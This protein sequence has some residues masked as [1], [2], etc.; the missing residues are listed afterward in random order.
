M[1]LTAGT[2]VTVA[3]SQLTSVASEHSSG[4]LT[5][6]PVEARLKG[7]IAPLR[8]IGVREGRRLRMGLRH[9]GGISGRVTWG[10]PTPRPIERATLVVDRW[11]DVVREEIPF[12]VTTGIGVGRGR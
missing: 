12:D 4:Q 10:I 5:L 9:R 6:A 7:L 2:T 11:S 8:R 3:G 1:A